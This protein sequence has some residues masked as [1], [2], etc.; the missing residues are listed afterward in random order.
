VLVYL[1]CE[2]PSS[3][4][5]ARGLP[6]RG[7]RSL[8]CGSG[9]SSAPFHSVSC[10]SLRPFPLHA[11]RVRVRGAFFL[12]TFSCSAKKKSPAAGLPPAIKKEAH[13]S[14]FV[15]IQNQYFTTNPVWLEK[16]A[17]KSSMSWLERTAAIAPMIGSLRAPDL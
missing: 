17:A 11:A 6:R 1:P 3:T 14:F 13:T 10:G 5:K 4:A 8:G 15:G 12:V 16:Y 7:Q 9:S 2:P